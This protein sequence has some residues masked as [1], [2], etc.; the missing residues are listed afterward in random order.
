MNTILRL[1]P[2]LLIVV[3]LN[4]VNAQDTLFLFDGAKVPS[5]VLEVGVNEIKYKKADNPDGPT[6]ITYR[7]DVKIIRYKNGSSDTLKHE[8]PVEIKTTVAKVSP[9]FDQTPPIYRTGPIYKQGGRISENYMHN[10]LKRVKDYQINLHVKN[11]KIAKG[12]QYVGFLAIPAVVAGG[13]LAFATLIDG[14][15]YGNY[16]FTPSIACGFVAVAALSTTI[17]AHS[18]RVKNNDAAIKIYNEKY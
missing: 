15:N 3:F 8:R 13:V 18:M 6:Y 2:F 10:T 9:P 11:A 4:K 14:S 12:V 17:T 5:E 1:F 16:N 7:S